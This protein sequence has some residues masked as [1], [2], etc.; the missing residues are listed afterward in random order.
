M[1]DAYCSQ[2]HYAEHLLPVLAALPEARRGGLYVHP[3]DRHDSLLRGLPV[4]FGYPS[5]RGTDPVVIAGYQDQ[6]ITHRPVVLLSHGAGQT[7]QGVDMGS[8]DGGPGRDVVKL[9]LCPNER[10]AQRNRDR[11]PHSIAVAV[12][13]PKL[14]DYARIEGPPIDVVAVAFHW[15]CRV[16]PEAGWAW[17]TWA[18]AVEKLARIRPVIGHCHPRA[19]RELKPWFYDTGIEYV[20]TVPELLDRARTL[21]VDNSS[22]AYEWAACGRPV[23]FLDDVLWTNWNHGLRFGDPLPGPTAGPSGNLADLQGALAR[24]GRFRTERYMRAVEVYGPLD[25]H[26]SRR[27]ADAILETFPCSS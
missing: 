10:S 2:P 25:G 13:C 18:G 15:N 23:V 20:E 1:I 9:H 3:A 26:A 19:R 4:A 14:D 12:G 27:A 24:T 21:V 16:V 6:M 5:T 17:S 22:L 7:Y 11:Y 8:Y